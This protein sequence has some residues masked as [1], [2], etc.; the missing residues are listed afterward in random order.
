MRINTVWPRMTLLLTTSLSLL[1][2]RATI[3]LSGEVACESRV[4]AA[5]WE[6]SERR[7][8]LALIN[9]KAG[10]KVE[11]VEL[12]RAVD[13]LSKLTDIEPGEGPS[14]SGYLPDEN[15]AVTLEKWRRW[16][17]INK[18]RLRFKDKEGLV[19]CRK[20]CTL[21]SPTVLLP[22]GRPRER[23]CEASIVRAFWSLDAS[24][25][26]RAIRNREEGRDVEKF[27]LQILRPADQVQ[28][29][30][31]EAAL[32]RLGRITG[33]EVP[34]SF[35]R[36]KEG[37]KTLSALLERMQSWFA[38]NE[39]CVRRDSQRIEIKRSPWCRD[40]ALGVQ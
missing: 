40:R 36:G 34:S 5:I 6:Q 14:F 18:D 3:P 21:G 39:D 31:L 29:V 15:L 2:C 24:L 8:A 20:D 35:S 26:E 30:D 11:L 28:S 33:V 7:V 12:G 32:R 19:V 27:D 13:R 22:A 10:R 38:R 9:S 1:G 4:V 16:Y 37:T 23:V 25:A 17:G